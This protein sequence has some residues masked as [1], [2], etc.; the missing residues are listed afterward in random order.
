[1]TMQG[2]GRQLPDQAKPLQRRIEA[3]RGT[4]RSGEPMPEGLWKAA[5]VL[6]RKH[7]TYLI[8]RGL[9]VDYGALKQRVDAASR[10]ASGQETPGPSFVELDGAQLFSGVEATPPTAEASGPVLEL[11]R[12][13]GARMVVRLPPGSALDMARLAA[14]FCGGVA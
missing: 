14:S 12:Q 5:V 4:R 13:D 2:E 8:A 11:T 6:A 10:A 9:P 3:W 1:M 7:G